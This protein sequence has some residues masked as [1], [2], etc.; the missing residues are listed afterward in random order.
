MKKSHAAILFLHNKQLLS[1]VPLLICL[2][3]FIL[4]KINRTL[5]IF[6]DK[7]DAYGIHTYC[8]KSEDGATEMTDP[9]ISDN[10]LSFEYTLRKTHP[11][12]YAGL[13]IS[14]MP[15]SVFLDISKYDY[16]SIELESENAQTFAV[17][18]KAFIDGYTELDRFL[19]HEF[20]MKEVSVDSISARH[21][22][23][24]DEFNH[25]AWWLEQTKIPESK[26][27][28]PHFSKTI[29]MQIQNGLFT[30]FDT[31]IKVSIRE[32]VF[33][34]NIRLSNTIIWL[35]MI[36]YFIIY[37]VVI[38]IIQRKNKVI[39][40][41]ELDVGNDADEDIKRIMDTVAQHYEDSEFTVEKLARQA[42]VSASKIP[43]ML[44]VRF[45]MNFKQ[46]L[47]T[48]RI[49][50]AKRLLRETDKQIIT[51]AYTVGYNN[52]PHF[53]RTFK[54]FEGISPKE[55]RKKSREEKED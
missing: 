9:Q 11:Y 27:K 49:A 6:P 23:N 16:L 30:P 44:K 22:I 47:N 43:G 36:S 14:L 19:T 45:K 25:P 46:Y 20:L 32:I 13:F 8:D 2:L 55:Y 41:K 10:Q 5:T 21:I 54:Q 53:N 37:L 50:E 35:C 1:I 39:A 34:K 28:K 3:A 4:T 26:V 24:L 38:L 31:P 29:S 51:C 40:Y 12:P 17:F 18:L 42:G 15:D 48:I 52:I 33:V 7:E